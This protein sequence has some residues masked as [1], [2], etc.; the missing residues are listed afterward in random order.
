MPTRNE[1]EE[2]IGHCKWELAKCWASIVYKITGP[3]GNS[4][5]LPRTGSVAGGRPDYFDEGCYWTCQQCEGKDYPYDSYSL[6]IYRFRDKNDIIKIYEECKV[7]S[8]AVR[9]VVNLE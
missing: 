2:L 9:P 4:I 6:K 8:L 3:S 7:F 5:F 1:Y